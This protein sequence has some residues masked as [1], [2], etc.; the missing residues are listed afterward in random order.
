MLPFYLR[1]FKPLLN[2]LARYKYFF[3]NLIHGSHV[4]EQ[5]LDKNM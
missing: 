5:G 2:T 3:F 4:V 1:K